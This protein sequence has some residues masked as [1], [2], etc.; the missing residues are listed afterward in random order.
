L[1]HSVGRLFTPEEL[2]LYNATDESTP[3]Y[4]AIMGEV[5]DG[6]RVFRSGCVCSNARCL[7]SA[8]TRNTT[9]LRVD[10]PSFAAW[11]APGPLSLVGRSAAEF[12]LSRLPQFLSCLRCNHDRQ[13]HQRGANRRCRWPFSTGYAR[14][15]MLCL[16]AALVRH[17]RHPRLG[18]LLSQ[19]LH[20]RGESGRVS[21]LAPICRAFDRY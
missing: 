13:F 1:Q 17:D 15:R 5:F 2:A 21:A 19:G 6:E 18:R 16:K 14:P 11:T 10:T 3:N 9:V 12:R 8:K 7:Q 20:P 4:L